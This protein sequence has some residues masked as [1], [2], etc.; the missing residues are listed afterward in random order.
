MTAVVAV[1]LGKTGCRAVLWRGAESS[2]SVSSVAGAP[3]LAAP[4]GV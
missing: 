1:D 2:P 4:D 3:G